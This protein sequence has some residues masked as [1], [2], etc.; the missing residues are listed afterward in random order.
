MKSLWLSAALVVLV[1][2][3]SRHAPA[4]PAP[5][6]APAA[7]ADEAAP[8]QPAEE[9]AAPSAPVARSAP[10][11]A[12]AAPAP[13]AKPAPGGITTGMTREELLDRLGVCAHLVTMVPGGAG[14]RSV[15]VYE[16]D[17]N[18]GD[19]V[20]QFG[21]R[22]Y[23]VVAGKLDSYIDGLNRAPPPRSPPPGAGH[24]M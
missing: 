9:A 2:G 16:P 12:K 23:M 17:P 6:A 19:C 10:S 18:R 4:P 13:A 11:V 21:E 14:A 15:E 8:T 24:H 3:C 7:A 22:Q 5:K 1:G 20:K